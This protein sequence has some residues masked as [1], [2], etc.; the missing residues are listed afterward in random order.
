MRLERYTGSSSRAAI[1]VITAVGYS[2]KAIITGLNLH[3][4]MRVPA[5]RDAHALNI[6]GS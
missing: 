5:G 3:L 1:K 6:F 2:R 4:F